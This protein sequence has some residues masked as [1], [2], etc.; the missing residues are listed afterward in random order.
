MSDNE[1]PVL[2]RREGHTLVLRIDRPAARNSLSGLVL[3][4]L[5]V[6]LDEAQRDA[7]VRVVVI[8]GCE[9]VFCAGADITA[10]DRLR[11]QP[12]LDDTDR[13]F[14]TLLEEFPKPIIA[15]VEGIAYGGGL[16]LALACDTVIAGKSA[17]FAVPEVK[18]GVIPGAGG[19][20]RLIRA[21]GKARAMAMLL[22]GDP[23]DAATALATG[24][25]AEITPDG[26]ALDR[27]LVL[28]GRIAANSPLAVALAK[29]AALASFDT[30]LR[31]GLRHEQ[32][33][34]HV[35]VHSDDSHEGQAAFL[36]KR[37]P[38]FT[39]Q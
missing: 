6:A 33:N 2:R 19:T 10:F 8:T 32:R 39:G 21:V 28:A 14:W 4:L 15:A 23:I 35:A 27:A 17:R 20:Q 25:A 1:S 11:A 38:Q 9:K 18:L 31:Q 22:S 3:D 16:E 12:L 7:E 37:A 13:R 30:S 29:D 26:A 24:V 34:F 36:E 5:G